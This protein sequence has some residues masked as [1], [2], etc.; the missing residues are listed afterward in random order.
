MQSKNVGSKLSKK[1]KNNAE[2]FWNSEIAGSL[3]MGISKFRLRPLAFATHFTV[4]EPIL[5]HPRCLQREIQ[6]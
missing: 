6:I 3:L 1:N 4:D 2:K 5:I